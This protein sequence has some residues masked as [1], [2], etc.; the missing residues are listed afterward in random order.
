MSNV[1]Q[2]EKGCD[3]VIY[4]QDTGGG[5]VTP[6]GTLERKQELSWDDKSWTISGIVLTLWATM[7]FGLCSLNEWPLW[8]NVL[9]SVGV[10]IGVFFIIWIFRRH[11][12]GAIKRLDRI[13]RFTKTWNG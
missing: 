12:L 3:G 8:K 2:K 9:I 7:S 10:L 1:T 6:K 13:F 5:S 11:I 4:Q